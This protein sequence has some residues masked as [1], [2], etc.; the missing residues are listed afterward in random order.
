MRDVLVAGLIVAACL[1]STAS[2]ARAQEAAE[3]LFAYD[4]TVPIDLRDSVARRFEGGIALHDVSFTS[5][6]GGRVHAYIVVPDGSGP[7]PVVLFGPWGLGNR[8]EF[9]PEALLYARLG[10]TAMIVD[11]PW[12]RPPPDRRAQG[13]IEQPEVDRDVFAQAVVDLRRALD[14]MLRRPHADSAH[15]IYVGHSYG[16]QFGAALTAVDRRVKAAVLMAGVPDNAT[17]LVESQDPDMIAY[18]SRSTPEQIRRYLEVNAP[19]DAITWIGKVSP[20]PVLMQFAEFERAFDTRAMQRYAAAAR[21]P[22]TVLWYP[23]GHELNDLTALRDRAVWVAERLG[24][25]SPDRVLLE[26]LSGRR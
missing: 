26:L 3:S 13:P 6:R 5:P 8:T 17:F 7:F 19:L 11:W 18:R 14:F 1:G 16:A 23:T 15:V 4:R 12:T 10:A 24:L 9:I 20:T 21:E 25:E 2:E 22:K